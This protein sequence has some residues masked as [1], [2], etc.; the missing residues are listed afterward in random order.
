MNQSFPPGWYPDPDGGPAARYW[1]GT[2]WE[3]SAEHTA[4]QEFPLE[5]AQKSRLLVPVLIGAVCL[6]TGILLVLL[7][8]KHDSPTAAPPTV[9]YTPP[10]TITETESA[11]TATTTPADRVAKMV[12]DAM[13]RHFDS[14]A[15]KLGIEVLDVSLVNKAGNEYKGFAEIRAGNGEQRRVSVEVTADGDNVL[16]EIPPGEL[17][18][19]FESPPPPPRSEPDPVERFK[20]C[21][22]G[23]SGVASEDTSCAFA[24]S[25]RQSWH[26]T[27]F[28]VITAYSPVTKRTYLMNCSRVPT[29][30]WPDAKRCVGENPAGA[31][32][33]VYID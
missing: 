32:L 21:P 11:P 1:N 25:V 19:G 5:P 27:P 14:E 12:R 6:L 4:P 8:P 2:D 7:W 28:S 22:S 30:V 17:E 9:T 15:A 18:F 16:W 23:S 10:V 3:G 31:P 26:Q 33:I 20:I 13:Q 24:D 29:D